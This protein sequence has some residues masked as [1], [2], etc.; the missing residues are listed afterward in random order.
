MSKQAEGSTEKM[1]Y[2]VGIAVGPRVNRLEPIENAL[3]VR[4]DNRVFSRKW[5]ISADRIETAVF[6][7]EYLRKF[8]PPMKRRERMRALF[9][10][11]GHVSDLVPRRTQRSGE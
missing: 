8:D 2:K 7:C 6:S 4:S 9:Q 3:P 11:C 5:G 10:G 1:G